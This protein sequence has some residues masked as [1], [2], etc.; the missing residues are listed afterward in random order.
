MNTATITA[1]ITPDATNPRINT[2][3]MTKEVCDRDGDVVLLDGIQWGNYEKN[4]VV[5]FEHGKDGK[6]GKIPVGKTLSASRVADTF[7]ARTELAERP[8]THPVNAEW[9]PDTLAALVAQK[10]LNGVSIGFIEQA[11]RK[12]TA[13]DRAKYGQNTRKVITKADLFE[14]SLTGAPVNA[15]SLAVA[16]GKGLLPADSEAY[17]QPEP[18]PE[19]VRKP[20][21][22]SVVVKSGPMRVPV[23]ISQ[24]ERIREIVSVRVKGGLYA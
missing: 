9:I 17:I 24:I 10:C 13:Q 4:P 22:V 16:R 12:A 5:M 2:F 19:P 14:I 8:E 7:Q 6:T 1:T 18:A 15:E 3:V 23:E 20:V 11:S 21:R